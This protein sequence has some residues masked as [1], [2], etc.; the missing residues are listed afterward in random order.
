M[1]AFE[2]V[3]GCHGLNVIGGDLVEV[4]PAYDNGGIT[5]MLGANLLYEMLCAMPR[6]R[7]SQ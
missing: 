3:R 2:I 5:A 4:A 6:A 7:G 1:Q